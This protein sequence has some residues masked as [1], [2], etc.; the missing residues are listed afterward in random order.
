MVFFIIYVILVSLREWAIDSK[1]A[2]VVV[3]SWQSRSYYVFCVPQNYFF[4]YPKSRRSLGE[5]GWILTRTAFAQDDIVC[6]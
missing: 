6:V 5:G 2:S 4:I 3:R 1:L